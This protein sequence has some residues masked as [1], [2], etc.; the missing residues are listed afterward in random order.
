MKTQSLLSFIVLT[1]CLVA[2]T[3]ACKELKNP[4]T[5]S[6]ETTSVNPQD[7]VEL[8]CNNLE[9][10]DGTTDVE[11]TT[12]Q[13]DAFYTE[14]TSV[15][16][17]SGISQST[18][19]TEAMGILTI[20]SME[21]IVLVNSTTNEAD[22]WNDLEKMDI[23]ENMLGSQAEFLKDRV[24]DDVAISVL[25]KMSQ[26]TVDNLNLLTLSTPSSPEVTQK[27]ASSLVKSI[28]KSS[29]TGK[30]VEKAASSAVEYMISQSTKEGLDENGRLVTFHATL[31]GA[32]EGLAE[33]GLNSD[34]YKEAIATLAKSATKKAT[35]NEISS[36]KS[37]EE[38]MATVDNITNEALNAL[39]AA[40]VSTTACSD[41]AEDVISGT[42]EELS[43]VLNADELNQALIAGVNGIV[44]GLEQGGATSEEKASAIKSGNKAAKE[45]TDNAVVS[46]AVKLK[47][48]DQKLSTTEGAEENGSF[49]VSLDK[50]P[51]EPITVNIISR[52]V[53]EGTVSPTELTLN[54][55]NWNNPQTIT[56]L[57]QDDYIVDDEI[58]YNIII[59]TN[60]ELN[61]TLIARNA[62]NDVVG[63][64]ITP[65]KEQYSSEVGG[66][67]HY[68]VN[69][70]SKPL[71]DIRL[72]WAITSG[73]DSIFFN[74]NTTRIQD[75]TPL[76]YFEP[77][78]IVLQG[79]VCNDCQ[80]HA[81]VSI[82]SQN[83]ISMD[84]ND[85]DYPELTPSTISLTNLKGGPIIK[86]TK[87]QQA[88]NAVEVVFDKTE[89]HFEIDDD[90][91]IYETV[92][93]TESITMTYAKYQSRP[94][95][96]RDGECVNGSGVVL[97]TTQ[98]M[99]NSVVPP[100][101][102]W[103]FDFCLTFFNANLTQTTAG[104]GSWASSYDFSRN[105]CSIIGGNTRYIRCNFSGN[106]QSLPV[107]TMPANTVFSGEKVDGKY[108]DKIGNDVFY[109]NSG[110]YGPLPNIPAEAE[111][112][113]TIKLN[114]KKLSIAYEG[115]TE[116]NSAEFHPESPLKSGFWYLSDK[117]KS[118]VVRDET[119]SN[120]N[121][122]Y[123]FVP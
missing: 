70:T 33:A 56:I 40:G 36:G 54:A 18:D 30:G 49:T 20:S 101:S 17:E 83:I 25:E 122:F 87:Y 35:V 110:G 109:L 63:I 64:K 2:F 3:T 15:L 27:L 111:P 93:E 66:Q 8:I 24:T 55:E 59:K 46:N 71:G 119:F 99:D 65:T 72:R 82:K 26:A 104:T 57:P 85:P 44:N 108:I 81:S 67:A 92:F 47:I 29:I 32:V 90:M 31:K 23:M 73:S 19:L 34:E 74:P 77:Q 52:D 9:K 97:K 84:G 80:E 117:S 115:G 61:K 76:N 62:D 102:S 51:A 22:T 118:F 123:V 4:E 103:S 86:T 79:K 116:T 16:E 112:R 6:G 78:L 14:L 37:N 105:S 58:S 53:S 12:E 39:I 69:L 11:L 91:F 121:Y 107:S 1:I 7:V 42:A 75:F 120:A 38:L 113:Q 13:R 100:T 28:G 98:T 45:A 114:Y 96:I 21:T 88:D 48:S 41:V 95:L 89:I 106:G 43:S 68:M 5:N 10:I 94:L 60:G 50:E